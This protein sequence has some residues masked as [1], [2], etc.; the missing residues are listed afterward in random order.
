MPEPGSALGS[1]S[2]PLRGMTMLQEVNLMHSV[3]LSQLAIHHWIQTQQKGRLA[4]VGSIAGFLH[5]AGAPVYSAT[6]S[7]IHDFVRRLGFLRDSLGIHVSAIVPHV[8]NVGCDGPVILRRYRTAS[9]PLS[10]DRKPGTVRDVGRHREGAS[11]DFVGPRIHR[12]RHGGT[13]PLPSRHRR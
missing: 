4:L 10:I 7:A 12:R 11:L 5:L 13:G 6:K 8:F 1:G 9:V 2:N 3:G